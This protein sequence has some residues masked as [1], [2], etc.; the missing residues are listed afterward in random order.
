MFSD[1]MPV[2]SQIDVKFWIVQV[3]TSLAGEFCTHYKRNT[4]EV[5][6]AAGLRASGFRASTRQ[7]G[8]AFRIVPSNSSQSAGFGKEVTVKPL[9]RD[10]Y[11][12]YLLK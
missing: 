9:G 3:R 8:Q 1:S 10:P 11:Q 12:E 2:F 7:R 4:I 6:N 5:M